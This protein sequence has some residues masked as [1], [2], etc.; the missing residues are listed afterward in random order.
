RMTYEVGVNI[1]MYPICSLE[2]PLVDNKNIPYIQG[3]DFNITGEG[4]IVWIAGGKSPGINPQTGQGNVYSIRYLY[5]AYHYVTDIINEVRQANVTEGGVRVPERMAYH[6]EIV[7][8]F[9]FHSQNRGDPKNASVSKTPQ[10][11]V[12]EPLDNIRPQAPITVDMT[13]FSEEPQN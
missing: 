7:R 13:K 10:R 1:P 2:V 8:E 3:I 5:R 9:I 4:N 12:Q 6:A 11:A